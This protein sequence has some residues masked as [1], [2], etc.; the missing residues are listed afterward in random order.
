MRGDNISNHHS[1]HSAQ[2]WI[3]SRNPTLGI[4]LFCLDS[5]FFRQSLVIHQRRFL[6]RCFYH[7]SDFIRGH[8]G[9]YVLHQNL[10]QRQD[11]FSQTEISQLIEKW[12]QIMFTRSSNERVDLRAPSGR[13]KGK[14]NLVFK[15]SQNNKDGKS[16]EK[17]SKFN[18]SSRK[19]LSDN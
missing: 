19:G 10:Q 4:R 1:Y 6:Q 12:F 15:N 17:K 8:R 3:P 16:G 14:Q 11:S 9:R 2:L 7:R 5:C 18:W 13:P